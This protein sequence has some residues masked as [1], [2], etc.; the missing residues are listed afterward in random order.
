MHYFSYKYIRDKKRRLKLFKR[1]NLLTILT[2]NVHFKF[3]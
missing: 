2:S 3:N 1:N